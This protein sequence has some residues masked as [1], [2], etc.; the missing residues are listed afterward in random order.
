M[1]AN[2]IS[3]LNTKLVR[4]VAKLDIS[5][6]KRQ[7]KIVSVD[8]TITGNTDSTQPFYRSSNI[9][10]L[11]A[12]PNPYDS[13][14]NTIN[15]DENANEGGLILGRPWTGIA[16]LDAPTT[17]EEALPASTLIDLQIWYDA[18]DTATYVPSAADESTI[19]QWEDKSRFAHNANPVGGATTRPSFENTILQGGNGYLEFD[20]GDT[21][22]VNPF[23]LLSGASNFTAFIVAKSINLTTTNCLI[24]TNEGDF[25][26]VIG[27][28]SVAVG[29]SGTNNFGT[30]T[31]IDDDVNSNVGNWHQYSLVF[32]GTE[33]TSA[34]R[35][36]LRRNKSNLSMTFTGTI[37]ATFSSTNNTLL[38]GSRAD[39][40]GKLVGYIGEIIMFNKTLTE[41]EYQNVENYLSTKWD[42]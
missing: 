14:Q 16:A 24:S 1:S 7:G 42:L 40:T 13:G 20:G 35:L 31:V 10:E 17:I 23:T 32:N 37:P 8:G 15:I 36:K 12:L 18:A 19:T 9:Y 33:A 4:Q 5:Q 30:A 25:R 28:N 3:T 11:T 21:L 41:V 29:M 27:N 38:I 6:A 34:D 22:S 39:G 2:G 26:L